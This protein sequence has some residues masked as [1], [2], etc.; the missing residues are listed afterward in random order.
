MDLRS[1]DL[2]IDHHLR[3]IRKGHCHAC[4]K[5]EEHF[6]AVLFKQ[7]NKEEYQL[8]HGIRQQRCIEHSKE[9]LEQTRQKCCGRDIKIS[10]H[11]SKQCF[12]NDTYNTDPPSVFLRGIHAANNAP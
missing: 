6:H 9:A 8:C 10:A 3:K 11:D 1:D 2:R 12:R 4:D 5:T 7:F